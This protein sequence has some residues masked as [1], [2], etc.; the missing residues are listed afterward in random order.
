MVARDRGGG[1]RRGARGGHPGARGRGTVPRH[2]IGDDG[3]CRRSGQC[4]APGDPVDGCPRRRRGGE[5]AAHRRWR[6]ARQRRGL[7]TRVCGM[8]DPQGT[9][10]EAPRA[11]ALRSRGDTVRI[12]GLHGSPPDRA[13]RREPQQRVDTLALSQRRR[14]MAGQPARGHRPRR[15]ARQMARRDRRAGRGHR[16]AAARA[17]RITWASNHRRWWCKAASTRSS[18]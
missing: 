2:D 9:L 6:A 14:R 10:A 3:R 16:P 4:A 15:R 18:A 1:A 12:P 7:G 13:Q 11:R 5:R 8:D 17:L